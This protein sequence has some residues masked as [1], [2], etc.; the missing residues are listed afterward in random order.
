MVSDTRGKLLDGAIASL[1]DNGI[2][3]VSARVIAATAGVNQA[4]IFYHFGSVS[5][6]IDAACREAAAGQVAAYRPRFEGVSSLRELLV[7][8]QELHARQRE[9]GNVAVLAQVLAGARYDSRLAGAARSA[10]LLWAR[11]IESTL[12]RLLAGT[13]VAEVA[14]AAALAPVVTA[15]FIGIE[16][17]EGADPD[18]AA[19]A[20]VALD[21]LSV[22][23]EV[24]DELGPVARRAVRSRIRRARASS[25]TR[26]SAPA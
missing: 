8:G 7:L 20:F 5:E 25:H 13:P 16:L 12:Q 9:A 10:L 23:I 3:G 1:R 6:L 11:E 2:A 15:A 26:R 24:F 22:L 19:A 18:G 21:Q 4:L 17:Y 14:D